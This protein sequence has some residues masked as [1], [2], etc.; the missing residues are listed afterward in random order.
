MPDITVNTQDL[1][2]VLKT[3]SLLNRQQETLSEIELILNNIMLASYEDIGKDE[4]TDKV[5]DL[6]KKAENI[7]HQLKLERW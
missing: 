4:C 7:I 1:I 3:V 2:Y 6:V 5:M